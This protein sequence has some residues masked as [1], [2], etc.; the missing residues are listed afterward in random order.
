MNGFVWKAT[1][2]DPHEKE[3]AQI[4]GSIE[5]DLLKGKGLMEKVLVGMIST[6]GPQE[7]DA[8]LEK[9]KRKLA[10]CLFA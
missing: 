3:C 1:K 8:V 9:A 5:E 6:L 7:F 4:Y 10:D 2:S